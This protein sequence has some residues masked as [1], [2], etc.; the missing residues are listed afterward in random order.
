MRHHLTLL[1]F[2]AGTLPIGAAISVSG[3][4]DESNYTG[5]RS[6][7]VDDPAGFTTTA[8]LNGT[9]IAVGTPVAV[10]EAGFYELAVTETSGAGTSE[11]T[12]L[13]NIREPGRGSS[14][15]GLP[16]FTA[17]LL[18]N[19]APSAIDTG[20]LKLI[21]PKA[22]PD[23]RP[24]PTIGLLEKTNGDPLWLNARLRIADQ[25]SATI[26]LRRGFGYSFLPAGTA[27][28][29]ATT[30]SLSASN[31]ITLEDTTVTYTTL[32]GN[33]TSD[34]TFPDDARIH[35]TADL[36]IDPTATLTIGAGSLIRIADAADIHVDG[37]FVVNATPADPTTF[38][39]ATPGGVWG[40][41]FLQETTS[42]VD[43]SGAILYGSGADQTWFDTNSGYGAHRDEQA[44]FLVGPAVQLPHVQKHAHRRTPS[45]PANPPRM[46][47]TTPI[48]NSPNGRCQ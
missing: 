43:I 38:L 6:F 41:F 44:L 3:I 19:D 34:Q 31:A 7:T 39:P 21:T 36:T 30:A 14:E 42:T 47:T 29:D 40:G 9:G 48:R 45:S 13:F 25:P 20:T 23:D 12:F 8:T 28:A 32:S 46:N 35:I 33:I 18:V 4:T 5:E 17:V 1:L 37:A 16:A 10:S 15:T 22:F 27:T 26:Q 11:E 24:I 2:L